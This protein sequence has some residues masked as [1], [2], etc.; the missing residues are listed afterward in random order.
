MRSG[1]RHGVPQCTLEHF[2]REFGDRHLLHKV[3]AWWAERKPDET[4]L[5]SYDRHQPVNWLTL[6]RVSTALALELLRLGFRKGDFLAA[7]LPVALEHIFLE[8]ACFKIGVIHAPLDLRLRPPEVLRSLEML[9]PRGFAY[10]VPDLASVVKTNCPCVE[11]FFSQ[12]DLA[13]KIGKGPGPI[14]AGLQAA[15]LN[16]TAAVGENDAAQVIFTTGSTGS[17]KGALLSHRNITC[18]NLCLGTAFGFGEERILL[19]LPPSHVGGQAEVLMTA[20]FC[21]GSAVIL[22]VFDPIKSLE[23]IQKYRVSMLGQIP[24]MFQFEWRLSEFDHYDLSSLNKVVYGGQQVSRQF[25]SRMAQMAPLIATGLGLTETAGF[26]TYT[27]MT[28][29]VDEVMAGI[30][31]DMPAYAM[32]IRREMREDGKA[33]D[34]L[35]DG[36]VG[37]IC[38]CGPQTF[39]GYVDDPASTAKTISSDGFL[40]TGDLG[41][42]DDQG[43]HLSGRARWVIKPAGY[44]VFPGDV[45]NHIC[46]LS[47]KVAGCGAVGADHRLLSEAIVAFVE[48][49]AGVDLTVQEL[50]QHARTMASYMRPLHYVLLEAGQMPL[51]RAAKIDYVRLSETAKEEVDRLRSQGRWDR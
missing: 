41:W 22:E 3:V 29:S 14:T 25:L 31:H 44:Q 38:F 1:V 27:P 24:A 32:S 49:K 36:E 30:G 19:N 12:P 33:G 9:K 28:S 15:F 51:N 39:L 20:L 40:Y 34:A 4:A 6:D 10:L 26:C 43:L 50:R 35:P 42:K 45:E 47:D 21:G 5:I 2:E 16:A 7:S 37:N 8:Y 17:P 48:K 11:H 23:A 18:Q 13:D 46:A